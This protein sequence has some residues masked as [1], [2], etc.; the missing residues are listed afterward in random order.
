MVVA[1]VC[2]FVG[3]EAGHLKYEKADTKKS[4]AGGL[5][6]GGLNSCMHETAVALVCGAG[7]LW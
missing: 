2:F 6:D 1:I 4:I 3:A 5:D 7:L